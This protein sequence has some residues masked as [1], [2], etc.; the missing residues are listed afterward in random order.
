MYYKMCVEINSNSTCVKVK[1]T[2]I[3]LHA[4]FN[5]IYIIYAAS[6]TTITNKR[7]DTT[8]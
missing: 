7:F 8:D 1:H 2:M 3:L 5:Y 4:Q 6:Y